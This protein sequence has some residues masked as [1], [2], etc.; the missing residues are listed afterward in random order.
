METE[1]KILTGLVIFATGAIG[2]AL[3]LRQGARD[4]TGT[5]MLTR[6][7]A[8]AAGGVFLGAGLIHMLGDADDTF[9]AMLPDVDFPIAYLIAALGFIAVLTIE[10]VVFKAASAATRPYAYILTLV[11]GFHSLLAGIALGVEDTALVGLAIAVAII[12][13][14]GAAAFALGMSFVKAGMSRGRAWRLLLTFS[15]VTPLGIF[16]GAAIGDTLSHGSGEVVEAVFD[17]LA[18]GSF[19][20][21]AAL[22]IIQEEFGDQEHSHLPGLGALLGGLGLMALIAVWT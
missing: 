16:V 15:C 12:A 22:D 1:F 10:R 6:M 5:S 17:A 7:A 9:T 4:V 18:A 19:L 11:L 2:G 14:K 3:A 21:I 8:A 13:H 20:Y